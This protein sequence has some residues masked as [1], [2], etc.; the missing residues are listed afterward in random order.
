MKKLAAFFSYQTKKSLKVTTDAASVT[1]SPAY[2]P[3]GEVNW[4]RLCSK[5][6]GNKF[7]SLKNIQSP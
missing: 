4:N 1:W 5:Q 6:V 2:T 3:S 7:Q